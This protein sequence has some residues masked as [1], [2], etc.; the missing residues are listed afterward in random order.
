MPQ[1]RQGTH[2]PKENWNLFQYMGPQPASSRRCPWTC[3]EPCLEEDRPWAGWRFLLIF[4]SYSL[5]FSTTFVAYVSPYSADLQLQCLRVPPSLQIRSYIEATPNYI[6]TDPTYIEAQ[7][8][9]GAQ[10]TYSELQL[11]HWGYWYPQAQTG[12]DTPQAGAPG[13]PPDL[14]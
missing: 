4:V 14:S 10:P 1:A 2:S 12:H 7:P 11:V 6:K 8:P 3:Q 9:G 13:V 5:I